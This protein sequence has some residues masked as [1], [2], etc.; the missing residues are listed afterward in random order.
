MATGKKISV[1]RG[2]AREKNLRYDGG[3]GQSGGGGSLSRGVWVE[4]PQTADYPELPR[5]L[6][7]RTVESL[8]QATKP[9]ALSSV[10]VLKCGTIQD[11]RKFLII[12]VG[13]TFYGFWWDADVGS[14]LLLGKS[15]SASDFQEKLKIFVSQNP[16]KIEGP[17]Q[18]SKIKII[19]ISN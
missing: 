15:W 6:A 5:T 3:S 14:W 1:W 19:K 4:T 10:L 9:T 13:D 8:G 11:F 17:G 18:N 16:G 2:R 7:F 12:S